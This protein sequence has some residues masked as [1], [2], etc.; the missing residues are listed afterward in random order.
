MACKRSGVQIP[1]APLPE[2]PADAGDSSF[3]DSARSGAT[4]VLVPILVPIDLNVAASEPAKSG[5]VSP[6]VGPLWSS[7]L[8]IAASLSRLSRSGG[9]R[10]PSAHDAELRTTPERRLV[11]EARHGILAWVRLKVRSSVAVPGPCSR[12]DQPL[13]LGYGDQDPAAH[14]HGAQAIVSEHAVDGGAGNAQCAAGLVNRQRH[15]TVVSLH[16]AVAH[17]GSVS[18]FRFYINLNFCYLARSHDGRASLRR[19]C[20][21]PRMGSHR[22]RRCESSDGTFLCLGGE[23]RAPVRTPCLALSRTR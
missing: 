2:S 19:R 6:V 23:G 17:C 21:P 4:P 1:S 12:S 20:L 13:E 16:L 18:L 11:L 15:A 3:A 7:W 22:A 14:V 8:V 10:T 5:G 9:P